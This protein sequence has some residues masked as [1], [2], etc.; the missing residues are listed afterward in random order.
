MND[1]PDENSIFDELNFQRFVALYEK[2]VSAGKFLAYYYTKMELCWDMIIM[3]ETCNFVNHILQ[4]LSLQHLSISPKFPPL[5]QK[6]I[7]LKPSI[8]H[9]MLSHHVSCENIPLSKPH[10]TMW[11]SYS[12]PGVPLLP[13]IIADEILVKMLQL[14]VLQ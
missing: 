8:Q 5:D 4:F 14:C 11:A 13:R 12:H 9:L 2:G 1:F 3:N 7:L 6:S 10:L